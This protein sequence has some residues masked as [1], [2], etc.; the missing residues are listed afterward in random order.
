MIDAVKYDT[1]ADFLR[2]V[3]FH[4]NA[5][6]ATIRIRLFDGG[7][8]LPCSNRDGAVRCETYNFPASAVERLEVTAS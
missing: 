2:G 7:A 4:V 3:S 1:A 5:T 6:S 8:W